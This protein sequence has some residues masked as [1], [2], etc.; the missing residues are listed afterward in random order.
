MGKRARESDDVDAEAAD[1]ADQTDQT[2]A[3]EGLNAVPPAL[4][5]ELWL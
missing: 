3:A 2:K 4:G 1:G 5:T